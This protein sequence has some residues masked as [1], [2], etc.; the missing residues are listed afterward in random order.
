MVI[1]KCHT[2]LRNLTLEQMF[3]IMIKRQKR[4]MKL[5]MC[6]KTVVNSI[7]RV[8]FGNIQTRIDK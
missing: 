4:T 3:E 7:V 1:D 6:M 2:N 8:A 5:I